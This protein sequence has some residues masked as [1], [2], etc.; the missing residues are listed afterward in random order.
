MKRPHPTD[1]PEKWNEYNQWLE[2]FRAK[3]GEPAVFPKWTEF[4]RDSFGKHAAFST[5]YRLRCWEREMREACVQHANGRRSDKDLL[6]LERRMYNRIH[7]RYGLI[8]G[9]FIDTD[10]RGYHLKVLPEYRLNLPTDSA[11]FGLLGYGAYE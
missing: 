8:L 5:S 6:D 2:K 3:K 10:P 9:L 1:S 4:Y 11:G 7:Q